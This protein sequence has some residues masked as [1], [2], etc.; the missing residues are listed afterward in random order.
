[1]AKAKEF[2]VTLD[3]LKET[4]NMV[5]FT[6]KL[7]SKFAPQHIGDPYIYKAALAEIGF[8]EGD[9]LEITVKVI[10]KGGK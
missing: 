8:D 4:K 5:R 10:K 2:T 1:M 9:E 3:V 6:E 7:E